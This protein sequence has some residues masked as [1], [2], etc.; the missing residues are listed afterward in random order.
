MLCR[1]L[2][3][4]LLLL[5]VHFV[6]SSQ[7][8][9]PSIH[10]TSALTE[11]IHQ[12]AFVYATPKC[13][14][15]TLAVNVMQGYCLHAHG[16]SKGIKYLGIFGLEKSIGLALITHKPNIAKP[17][18]TVSHIDHRT[19]IATSVR[20]MLEKNQHVQGETTTQ[21]VVIQG[22]CVAEGEKDLFALHQSLEHYGIPSKFDVSFFSFKDLIINVETGEVIHPS[23]F[24]KYHF[25]WLFIKKIPYMIH[26]IY[27]VLKSCWFRQIPIRQQFD[28]INEGVPHSYIKWY[29]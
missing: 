19:D 17:Y 3:L 18:I 9:S 4:A 1:A 21:A 15:R 2:T 24:Y 14:K 28:F 26:V 5:N 12:H 27:R 11:L 13:D 29:R 6:V 8:V 16:S 23:R 22:S 7:D 10:H 20:Y 25:S